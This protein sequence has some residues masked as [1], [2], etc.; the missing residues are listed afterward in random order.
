M[1]GHKICFSGE[2]WLIIPKLSLLP[3]LIHY[4]TDKGKIKFSGIALWEVW[5]IQQYLCLASCSASPTQDTKKKISESHT[6]QKKKI[7]AYDFRVVIR[8]W[9]RFSTRLTLLHSTAKTPWTF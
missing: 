6:R 9:P 2:I 1:M 5:G 3:L 4:S 8:H 7:R